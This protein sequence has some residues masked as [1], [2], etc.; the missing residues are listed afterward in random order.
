[1]RLTVLA[2]LL[3]LPASAQGQDFPRRM[4]VVHV[5]RPLYLKPLTS[6]AADGP[7]RV[8]E[9]TGRL[10]A[11]LRVQEG[12]GKKAS[13]QFFV[14]TDSEAKPAALPT[15]A[16]VMGAVKSFCETSRA[17]D[18]VVLVF[19]GHAFE[20]D[21]K[22]F[23]APLEGDPADGESLVAVAEVYAMLSES[24]AAQKVVVWDLC[25]RDPTRAPVRPDGGPMTEKLAKALADAPAG[26]QVVLPCGPGEFALEYAEPRGAARLFAGSA[27]LDALRQAFEDRANDHAPAPG[28]PVPI[29]A[30]FPEVV[31]YV[32]S[33][34]K[35]YGVTQ[36]PRLIG[37][38]P[39]KL[40]APDPKEAPARPSTLPTPKGE[41]AAEAASILEELALPPVGPADAGE[42]SVP[43]ELFGGQVLAPYAADVPVA[44]VLKSAEKYELRV[45]VLR[46]LQAVRDS[47]E[48]DPRAPGPVVTVAAPVTEKVKR[49]VLAAQGPV[50]LAITR[51]E[52]EL[53]N[54]TG[55]A[56]LRAKETRRWKA[57]YDFALA[58]VRLRLA[59][60][61]EYNLALGHVR[62]ETL[63]DLPE[64]VRGWR[65]APSARMQSR[66]DVRDL[67]AEAAAGF[68]SLAKENGGTPWEVLARR[69]L[70]TPPGL[71][72]EPAGK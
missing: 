40:A 24:K 37:A 26:V 41:A 11:A 47:A 10:A 58:Q 55:V 50:A 18:R 68:R 39:A 12:G 52:G 65:L 17:Q 16:V 15:R 3:V 72:W 43:A 69:A 32:A 59:V 45:A 14:L 70:L 6:R 1:M 66:K 7:D 63:P 27:L 2:L 57:H 19:A 8:R 48:P 60:L 71:R 49:A 56:E 34:A 5:G 38:R 31:R 21:G 44:E 20:K 4:M 54:L 46:A 13:P 64:G 35:A 33:A 29:D 67:A 42:S 61:N 25:R 22:A 51:L 53:E 9:A 30:V 36:T 23:V 62:T 28:D